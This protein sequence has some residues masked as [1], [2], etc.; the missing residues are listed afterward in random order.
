MHVNA[1]FV[2]FDWASIIIITKMSQFSSEVW[3]EMLDEE[4][5]RAH[6]L[7]AR[8]TDSNF[9]GDTPQDITWNL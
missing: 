6:L 1:L 8:Y 9:K 5:N 4:H 2:V 3:Q 7:K